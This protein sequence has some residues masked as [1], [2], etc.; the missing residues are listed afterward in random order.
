MS[1]NWIKRALMAHASCGAL[2][3]GQIQLDD[4]NGPE[5]GQ[6]LIV[7]T[8]KTGDRITGP[9]VA[10]DGMSPVLGGFRQLE[11][12]VVD[13]PL[14]GGSTTLSVNDLA[15]QSQYELSLMQTISAGM[16]RARVIYNANGSG[17]NLDITNWNSL[18]LE[19]IA[20]ET[21]ARFRVRFNDE[22]GGSSVLV[23]EM[24]VEAGG[25]YQAFFRVPSAQLPLWDVDEV[26]VE[27]DPVE[28]GAE[29]TLDSLSVSTINLT[30]VI[31]MD[32]PLVLGNDVELR[33]SN[34]GTNWI[35]RVLF[36]EKAG[37][38]MVEI[39]RT[40]TNRYLHTNAFQTDAGFYRVR[41]LRAQ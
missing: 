36:T 11:I 30:P 17:L 34:L 39:G 32:R 10:V 1:W 20:T 28:F 22:V 15:H 29:I 7:V 23:I 37:P 24:P 21:A 40:S 6:T 18:N 13:K 41:S 31:R 38:P 35:Y 26:V 19:G 3:W 33:W 14:E 16:V 5:G 2:V 8:A 4:F 9:N 12:E 27:I 25:P